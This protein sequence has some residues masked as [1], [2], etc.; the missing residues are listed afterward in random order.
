ML[1]SASGRG[2]WW[3]QFYNTYGKTGYNATLGGDGK[4]Y[5]EY[6]D[7]EILNYYYTDG[8]YSAK[9]TAKHFHIDG[10]TVAEVLKRNNI[11]P[12]STKE[13]RQINNM[14]NG[15]VV[16]QID[17]H[18]DVIINVFPSVSDAN[19]FLGKSSKSSG[20]HN[21]IEKRCSAS[22]GYRWD[23]IKNLPYSF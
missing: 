2:K 11:R 8:N 5:I 15:K 6:T 1:L 22:Y 4:S 14:V 13:V 10:K 9:T 21:V 16:C 7:D 19:K 23:Y 17:P 3:I 18:I 20:I 12:L